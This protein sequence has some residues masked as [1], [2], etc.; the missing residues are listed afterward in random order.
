MT[1]KI[2]E[3]DLK[4]RQEF[5]RAQRDKLLAQKKQQREEAAGQ[6]EAERKRLEEEKAAMISARAASGASVSSAAAVPV[7][8]A[9]PPAAATAKDEDD[10]KTMREALA[11]R[12][13]QDMI[14]KQQQS[15]QDK[16]QAASLLEE[17]LARAEQLRRNQILA[18]EKEIAFAR[19]QARLRGLG[20]MSAVT[21]KIDASQSDFQ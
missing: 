18:E 12:F 16:T 9:V 1:Q 17:Q 20:L 2:S 7:A 10:R 14:G 6:I 8:G 15:L 3:E 21:G 5:L 11:K 13:K 19:E 4:R